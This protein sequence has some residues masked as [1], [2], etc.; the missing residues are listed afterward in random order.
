[1]AKKKLTGYDRV[2][3]SLAATLAVLRADLLRQHEET[4]R[5]VKRIEAAS[6]TRGIKNALDE[7]GK[8]HDAVLRELT[9]QEWEHEQQLAQHHGMLRV[10]TGADRVGR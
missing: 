4:M 8:H 3:R 9:R 7:Y 5:A 2:R 10:L 6:E 1:M